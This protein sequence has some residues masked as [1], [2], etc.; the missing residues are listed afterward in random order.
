MRR[1]TGRGLRLLCH[2]G[3]FEPLMAEL[4]LHQLDLVLSGQG[5]PAAIHCS[6]ASTRLSSSRCFFNNV[7]WLK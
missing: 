5:A 7:N 4:A 6:C 3:E 1:S 2:E